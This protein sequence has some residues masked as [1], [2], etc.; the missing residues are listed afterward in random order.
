MGFRPVEGCLLVLLVTA[1]SWP[2]EVRACQCG[3]E[4]TASDHARKLLLDGATVFVVE[5]EELRFFDDFP[6]SM[7]STVRVL[8]GCEVSRRDIVFLTRV[9]NVEFTVVTGASTCDLIGSDGL[10][11]NQL[12]CRR[13]AGEAVC[14]VAACMPP[15]SS[16]SAL[17]DEFASAPGMASTGCGRCHAGRPIADSPTHW[18]LSILIA[19]VGLVRLRGRRGRRWASSP[20]RQ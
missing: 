11:S 12:I 19:V 3:T 20:R 16:V 2:V 7:R 1:A 4:A 17:C 9:E 14:K 15:V 13:D 6:R 10:K 8:G 5:V 18:H